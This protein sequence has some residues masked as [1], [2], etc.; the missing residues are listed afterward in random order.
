MLSQTTHCLRLKLVKGLVL[1]QLLVGLAESGSP[2][3]AQAPATRPFNIITLGDSIIWGQGLPESMKFRTL[4]ANW[5]QSQYG[6]TRNVVIWTTHAHSGAKTGWGL[7]PAE[8]NGNDPDTWYS[9]HPSSGYGPGY[10]YPGEVPFGYPSISF[11]IGMTVN[12]L[13]QRGVDPGTVDLVL[14]DGCINDLSADNILNPSLVETNLL[15]GEVANGPNWVRTKTNE[16][17]VTH[18]GSLL[19]QVTG[20]FPNAIVI[21]TG[22]Y[23]IVSGQTDLVKLS[24]YLTVLGFAGGAGPPAASVVGGPGAALEYLVGVPAVAV[25]LAA[26]LRA[27]LTDRSQAFATT[28]F[29]GLSNLVNQANQ[30]LATPRAALAWPNFSDDNAYAAPNSY[31]FLM[32]DFL[33]DEIRGGQGQAPPGDWNTQEGVAYYRGQECSIGHPSDPTCYAALVGHPN[34]KGAQ[35]YALAII[36]QLQGVFSARLAFP[37]W[38]QMSATSSILGQSAGQSLPLTVALAITDAS[39][40]QPLPGVQVWVQDGVGRTQ[41]SGTTATDGTVRLPFNPCPQSL[42]GPH[43]LPS[44]VPSPACP[45]YGTL[46]GHGMLNS[47]TPAL[48]ATASLTT[49]N[50]LSVSVSD[51]LTQTNAAGATVSVLDSQGHPLVTGTA[52]NGTASLSLAACSSGY[53]SACNATVVV[54]KAGYLSCAF[55]VPAAGSGGNCQYSP[56]AGATLPA[57]V[58]GVVAAVTN[59]TTGVTLGPVTTPQQLQIQIPALAATVST[60][61]PASSP[62]TDTV[63]VTSGGTPVIGATLSVGNST[64]VT[65]AGGVAVVTHAPCY[66]SGQ[67]AKVGVTTMPVLARTPIP[68]GWTATASKA[69]YQPFSFALP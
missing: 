52:V 46:A 62:V 26:A 60:N 66:A 38:P 43:L 29:N 41:S 14:L 31:L 4:V 40:K 7:Y 27:T 68:C 23:P 19:P 55:T 51:P 48:A 61:G 11:Q 45:I 67:V 32:E 17:C 3:F 50:A 28:A 37:K 65:N 34:P 1:L 33:A 63:T 22:Y 9:L 13:K 64:F 58:G 21:M 35:A 49:G 18:M 15:Q 69:G 20:Q 25:P 54:S 6:T 30:G 36:S 42:L 59:N 57:S 8:T 5:L 56:Y 10:P 53:L 44:S 2:A 47:W 24:E 39:T 16:L 12:D